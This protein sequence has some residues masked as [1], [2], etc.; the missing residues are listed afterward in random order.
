M[1]HGKVKEL[2]GRKFDIVQQG[3]DEGQVAEFI[4]ELMRQRDTLLE[5]INSLLSYIRLS[6]S[7]VEK[8]NEPIGS[9]GQQAENWPTGTVTEVDQNIQP[10]VET[11][12]LEQATI[13]VLPEATKAVEA[14]KEEPA[15]YQGELELAILP[16]VNEAGLLQFE[17][18]LR[19]SFQLKILSTDGSPS[20]GSLITVLL[21]EP[22]PLLQGLKQI[23]GVKEA[24]E[25][26]D[27]SAQVKETLS[28]L[29]KNKQGKGIWVT[30][31]AQAN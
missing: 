28:S 15:L 7:M 27:A 12:E 5:Q 2:G 13:P 20:K 23:P 31:E 25:E 21:S 11:T 18:S 10:A 29:L 16:P 14:N 1:S 6:K 19:N 9:F 17:R 24:V 3:L 22:Q 26:L 30:L 4:D 8:E